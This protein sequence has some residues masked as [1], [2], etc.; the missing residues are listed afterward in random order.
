MRG[1][2][3][4]PTTLRVL[5][6]NPRDHA[7]PKGEPKP[8]GDLADE[9]PGGLTE[10]QM[11]SWAHVMAHAPPGL[12]KRLD[13]GVLF[14]WVVAE[15]LHRQAAAAQAKVGLLVRVKTKAT[16]GAKDG[17][18]MASPY[19][20]I[21]NK[22]ALIMMKAA[23]ELGF[24]PTSRARIHSGAQLASPSMGSVA[25]DDDTSSRMSLSDFLANA[26]KPTTIN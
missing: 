3:P 24:T 20:N 19:L 22:Q 17:V 11:D 15:D 18:A 23:S 7:L 14:T 12:L 25:R 21:I 5:H 4:V 2:K 10:G 26:P 1:R 16:M 13:R 8:T 9:V 6:G